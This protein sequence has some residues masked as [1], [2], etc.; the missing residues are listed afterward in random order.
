[1]SD[2]TQTLRIREMANAQELLKADGVMRDEVLEN[3]VEKLIK[4]SMPKIH[5]ETGDREMSKIKDQHDDSDLFSQYEHI[6]GCNHYWKD[7]KYRTKGPYNQEG[8]LDYSLTSIEVRVA[9][10]VRDDYAFF[11]VFFPLEKN[12]T[13]TTVA[14][15]DNELKSILDKNFLDAVYLLGSRN[16]L[17]TSCPIHYKM[18][19]DVNI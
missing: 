17:K 4:E 9:Y 13:K 14:D 2:T 18:K 3:T 15:S 5:A 19:G 12:Y 6:G 8:E 10:A 1:M 16:R 11:V 7:V